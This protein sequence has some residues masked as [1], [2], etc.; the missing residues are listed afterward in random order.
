M[1]MRLWVLDQSDE[2]LCERVFELIAGVLEFFE[3]HG[4]D[5]RTT[6]SGRECRGGDHRRVSG[7]VK[8]GSHGQRKWDA[9]AALDSRDALIGDS[10]RNGIR[11]GIREEP[12][13]CEDLAQRLWRRL[14]RGR[15]QLLLE[16]L[17]EVVVRHG[18]TAASEQQLGDVDDLNEVFWARAEKQLLFGRIQVLGCCPELARDSR[19]HGN[20][21]RDRLVS[22]HSGVYGFVC[23]A[24]GRDGMPRLFPKTSKGR[25][26]ADHRWQRRRWSGLGLRV[27]SPEGSIGSSVTW[28]CGLDS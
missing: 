25:E 26:L 4:L 22:I 5:P 28:I 7:V 13:G 20:W 27:K 24:S 3:T 11:P 12:S 17:S 14:R 15:C 6:H 9:N 1:R 23:D 19:E 21:K 8:N 18:S 16:R 2:F 10:V